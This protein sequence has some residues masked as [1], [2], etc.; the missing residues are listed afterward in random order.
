M[1][2]VVTFWRTVELSLVVKPSFIKFD[3]KLGFVRTVDFVCWSRICDES[4]LFCCFVFLF[5]KLF[6]YRCA[7]Y[8]EIY[9]VHSQKKMHCLLLR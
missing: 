1:S 9:A 7:V 6:L 2:V 8:S 5:V 4:V 3:V